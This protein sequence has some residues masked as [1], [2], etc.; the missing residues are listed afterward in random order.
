MT[1]T[2][3]GL[4]C[5]NFIRW[6][7]SMPIPVLNNSSATTKYNNFHE[8]SKFLASSSENATLYSLTSVLDGGTGHEINIFF[9]IL[10]YEPTNTHNYFTNYH[11]ATCF[12]TIVSSSGGM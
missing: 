6:N 1:F 5:D 8:V 11:T 2:V 3:L 9:S 12:D 10:Y 4:T 7:A